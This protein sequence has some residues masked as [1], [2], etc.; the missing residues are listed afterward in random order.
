MNIVYFNSIVTCTQNIVTELQNDRKEMESCGGLHTL[1]DKL[2]QTDSKLSELS[3]Q[4]EEIKAILCTLTQPGNTCGFPFL[5]PSC[6][7]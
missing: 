4:L 1:R 5:V 7:N 3:L 2:D 6:H